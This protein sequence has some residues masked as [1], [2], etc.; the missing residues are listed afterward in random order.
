MCATCCWSGRELARAE[1]EEL[2]AQIAAE[3]EG[4]LT[5]EKAGA[6]LR[7][8]EKHFHSPVFPMERFCGTLRSWASCMRERASRLHKELLP[9]FNEYDESDPK[10]WKLTP[11][12]EAARGEYETE[13]AYRQIE[14]L[15]LTARAMLAKNEVKITRVQTPAR[16]T[17]R[18]RKFSDLLDFEEAEY[19]IERTFLAIQKS[20]L[21]AR[22]FFAGEKPRENI[23]P[24]HKGR[25]SGIMG[26]CPHGC[27][28]TG[29]I[30]DGVG[31]AT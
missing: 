22:M 16:A 1:V 9:K 4:P 10:S 23:C 18:S 30:P 5:D 28:L 8:L 12:A 31:A 7:R 26:D 3:R 19:R 17:E 29:W 13:K 11:E 2:R 6:M 25:W 14:D 21:L 24:V 27:Q 15:S 20:N